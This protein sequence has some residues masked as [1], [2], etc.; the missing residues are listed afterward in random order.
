[1]PSRHLNGLDSLTSIVNA[2]AWRQLNVDS[3]ARFT[4]QAVVARQVIGVRRCDELARPQA[5]FTTGKRLQKRHR[6]PRSRL[7]RFQIHR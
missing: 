4:P 6:A 7:P 3:T 1:M 2:L 5:A